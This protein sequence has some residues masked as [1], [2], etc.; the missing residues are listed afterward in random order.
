MKVDLPFGFVSVLAITQFASGFLYKSTRKYSVSKWTP[1][2]D[3]QFKHISAGEDDSLWGL[4]GDGEVLRYWEQGWKRLPGTI[5]DLS[6]LNVYIAWGIGPSSG[7]FRFNGDSWYQINGE[8]KKISASTQDVDVHNVEHIWGITK[9]NTLWYCYYQVGYNQCE[10]TKVP[11]PNNLK[12]IEIASSV[13][14]T[15]FGLFDIPGEKGYLTYWYHGG[16]WQL[17]EHRF[18]HISTSSN[19]KVIGMTPKGDVK[20]YEADSSTWKSVNTTGLMPEMV[21]VGQSVWT[22]SSKKFSFVDDSHLSEKIDES[23]SLIDL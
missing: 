18:S 1:V 4:S 8:L 13:D 10:W 12:I 14:G 11:K 7:V 2:E 5:Y 16:R 22:V 9:H 15:A 20:V 6:A 21:T 3:H 17:T 23:F 19:R